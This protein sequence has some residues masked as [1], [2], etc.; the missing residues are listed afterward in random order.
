MEKD[1][2][3]GN[4]S[5]CG[6]RAAGIRC[7]PAL[8]VALLLAGLSGSATALPIS[9]GLKLEPGLAVPSSGPQSDLF[10]PGGAAWLKGLVGLGRYLD[11]GPT[12]LFVGLPS[13][14][15]YPHD[16]LAFGVGGGLQIKRPMDAITVGGISPWLDLDLV[17]VRTGALDR[18]GFDVAGGVAWPLDDARHFWAGPFLRYFQIVQ[19]ERIGFDDRDAKIV[20][21]GASFF[22]GSSHR[23]SQPAS[24][25]M[26]EYCPPSAA[27]GAGAGPG[28]RDGDG[29]PDAVDQCPDLAG[30]PAAHGCPDRDN[31]TVPDAVDY[32]PDF[33]GSPALGGCPSYQRLQVKQNKLELEE[34]IFFAFDK[35]DIE[36]RSYPPLDEVV[37]VLKDNKLFHVRIEGNTDSTG[38][39][40]HN[41]VLSEGRAKSVLEYLVAHGIARNRLESKGMGAT[42]PT[43]TNTTLVGREDNRRVEFVILR[44][45]SEK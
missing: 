45:W 25:A 43:D 18:F 21:L 24:E 7:A 41:L 4:P 3:L 10:R 26:A 12:L 34:L 5:L 40:A 1:G 36:E 30:S 17:Y 13:A 32:C 6:G 37:K 31:D 23:P 22:Y 42:Q 2:R 8:L 39:P 15:S 33:P 11:V 14:P 38:T 28:D 35:T 44:N 29:V 16:G 27:C 20:V 19:P 9:Y